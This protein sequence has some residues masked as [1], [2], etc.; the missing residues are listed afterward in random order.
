MPIVGSVKIHLLA[1]GVETWTVRNPIVGI[2]L[3]LNLRIGIV[4]R[5]VAESEA[6]G[7]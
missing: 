7:I 6:E 5:G 1:L 2:A 4:E 3:L